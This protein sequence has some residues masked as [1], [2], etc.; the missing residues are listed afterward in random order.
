MSRRHTVNS[1][2]GKAERFEQLE[3]WKKA[4]ELVLKITK[5]QKIFLQRKNLD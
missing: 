3:V 5:L 4:H 1:R 2:Q